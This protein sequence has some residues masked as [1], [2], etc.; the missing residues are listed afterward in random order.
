MIK[1]NNKVLFINI[2]SEINDTRSFFIYSFLLN[3]Q[4]TF[5]AESYS[6]LTD[7]IFIKMYIGYEISL[8]GVL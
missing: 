6:G 3:I 8:S 2:Y 7:L 1:L 4:K 5:S